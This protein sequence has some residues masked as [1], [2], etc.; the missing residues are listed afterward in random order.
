LGVALPGSGAE[1]QIYVLE[2]EYLRDTGWL[3]GPPE[4]RDWRGEETRAGHQELAS[5][6]VF[7]TTADITAI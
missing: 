7:D 5:T 3:V 4:R 6:L 1:G 2:P